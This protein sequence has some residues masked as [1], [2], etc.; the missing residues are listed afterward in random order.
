MGCVP[1]TSQRAFFYAKQR[2]K[3]CAEQQGTVTKPKITVNY[4]GLIC[5]ILQKLHPALRRKVINNRLKERQRLAI[6][7]YLVSQKKAQQGISEARQKEPEAAKMPML[8]DKSSADRKDCEQKKIGGIFKSA[9]AGT[10]YGYYAKVGFRNLFFVTRMQRKF[11]DAVQDHI[12]LS[13]M[14]EQIRSLCV[15]KSF[16]EAV[17]TAVETVLGEEG[18]S[19]HKF[20][21]YCSVNFPAT[22][23][24]G[25]PLF[26]QSHHLQGALEV[27]KLFHDAK[28]LQFSMADQQV[29]ADIARKAEECWR[30]MREIF[31]A[32][33]IAQGKL[34]RSQ[35]GNLLHEF[36]ARQCL[37]LRRMI[38][39]WRK[40]HEQRQRKAQAAFKDN[41]KA[42]LHRFEQLRYKWEHATAK[43]E[44]RRT[45]Q[46]LQESRKRRWDGKESLAEF[47]RRVRCR[48]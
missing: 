17:K 24:I 22:Q 6:E 27:W 25:R 33:Q 19:Q 40:R 8:C 36:E 47:E 48:K 34:H 1:Q 31:V 4:A 35:V 3:V 11:A 45:N 23:W 42:L 46:K 16:P 41:E 37:V 7:A 9:C 32:L 26:V 38:A 20:L 39:Q 2:G 12:V 29:T 44:Q 13:R 30:Q 14:L 21:R 28:V 43:E 18:V 15:Q 5:K 10:V